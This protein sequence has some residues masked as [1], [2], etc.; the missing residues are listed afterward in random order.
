MEQQPERRISEAWPLSDSVYEIVELAQ[1]WKGSE[2]T[3]WN[4]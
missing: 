4:I 3:V 1:S 2:I